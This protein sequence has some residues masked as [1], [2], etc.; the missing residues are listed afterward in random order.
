M[1]FLSSFFLFYVYIRLKYVY[2]TP[3][4]VD[5]RTLSYGVHIIHITF[6]PPLYVSRQGLIRTILLI[7]FLL[8]IPISK[9]FPLFLQPPLQPNPIL[10][11]FGSTFPP[12]PPS[13]T[14]LP[15][16]YN[17]TRL[18]IVLTLLPHIYLW[19]KHPCM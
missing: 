8:C 15:F 14:A 16:Q 11:I 6:T 12:P 1:Y 3:F 17:H 9:F 10:I 4:G 19:T 5:D 7:S 2:T 13:Y 18:P